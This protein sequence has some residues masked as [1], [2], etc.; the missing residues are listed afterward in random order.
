MCRVYAYYRDIECLRY[1]LEH[2]APCDASACAAAVSIPFSRF[3]GVKLLGSW[4][5]GEREYY[6]QHQRETLECLKCL[7][8]H[9]CPWDARTC[10]RAARHANTLCLEYALAQGCPRSWA[11]KKVLGFMSW[12]TG[13]PSTVAVLDAAAEN[14]TVARSKCE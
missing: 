10:N 5:P 1:A 9:G 3:Y 14:M 7:H 6:D 4:H 2:G 11:R 12:M 13:Q 8:E